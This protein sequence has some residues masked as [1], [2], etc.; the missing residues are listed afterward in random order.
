MQAESKDA[1][2][3]V[4]LFR[5]ANIEFLPEYRQKESKEFLSVAQTVQHVVR[6]VGCLVSKKDQSC[7]Q[8]MLRCH[9][10]C[11]GVVLLL[12]PQRIM[13]KQWLSGGMKELTAFSLVIT[14][15]VLNRSGF[16]IWLKILYTFTHKI[17]SKT[18]ILKKSLTSVAMFE[19]SNRWNL[20]HLHWD[21][22]L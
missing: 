5:V 15:W 3:F 10:G 1:L 14:K 21:F 13:C 2:Y 16:Y 17:W 9:W 8:V 22:L 12:P 20:L 6:W 4:G 19:T 11:C 7:E 18:N